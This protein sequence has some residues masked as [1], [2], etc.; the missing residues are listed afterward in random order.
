M[1][2]LSNGQFVD[3]QD[4][5]HVIDKRISYQEGNKVSIHSDGAYIIPGLV[6]QHIHGV[7][8]VDVMDGSEESIKKMCDELVKEGTTTFLP[9]T[10]TCSV[11]DIKQALKVVKDNE[12]YDGGAKIGGVHLEGPFISGEYIGAQ[13]PNYL[14]PLNGDLLKELNEDKLI[15]MVTY[16]PELDSNHEFL[17]VL[18][19]EGITPSVGHSGASCGEVIKAHEN[20]L[21]CVTHFH[22]GQSGHSHREPGVVSAG[23]ATDINVELIVDKI[24]LHDDTVRLVDHV[25]SEDQIILV[26][27]SMSAKCM[28]DGKYD[29]GGQTVIK[30]GNE[31]RLESGTLAGSVLRLIDGVKNYHNITETDLAHAVKLAT[32]NPANNLK[33]ENIGLLDPGYYFDVVVLNQDLEVVQTFVNGCVKYEK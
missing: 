1:K 28:K 9:T 25:K 14:Q 11:D 15:K 4:N 21:K 30:T 10:M 31:A 17:N 26:T 27:D 8:G 20:G 29:L 3:Y 32:I 22:N 24:H 23:F 19:S 7:A 13:N 16:A 18:V 6:D 12:A 33:L 2:I 5:L